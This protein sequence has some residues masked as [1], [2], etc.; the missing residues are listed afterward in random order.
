[1]TA[2]SLVQKFVNIV[3]HFNSETRLQLS[4]RGRQSH[5]CSNG[6]CHTEQMKADYADLQ[7]PPILFTELVEAKDEQLR[8]EFL[9]NTMPLN[10][11]FAFASVHS[12]KA[13]DDQMAGRKDT[14]K[15]NGEYSFQFSDLK[16]VQGRRP[17][18]AQVYTL[19]PEDAQQ[20]RSES[21]NAVLQKQIK[22][23]IMEAG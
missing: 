19:M 7:S 10:N 6:Q 11:T 9:N 1:M 12:E 8:E 15:Y 3:V 16:A 2:V 5:C 22:R 17:T 21:I 18:F 4:S 20:L 13:P 23:E 14:V